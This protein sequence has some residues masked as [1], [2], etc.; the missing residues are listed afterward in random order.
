MNRIKICLNNQAREIESSTTQ[1]M[2]SG[3]KDSKDFI[4]IGKV[5]NI[6]KT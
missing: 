1:Q 2:T 3:N 6:T 4:K 5:M